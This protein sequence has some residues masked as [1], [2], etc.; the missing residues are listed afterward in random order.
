MTPLDRARR[1]GRATLRPLARALIRRR[2]AGRL[3][4]FVAAH[5]DGAGLPVFVVVVP[6]TLGW[7]E[8]CLRL[9]P[10]DVPLFLVGNGLRRR[11]RRRLARRFP[12]RPFFALSVPPGTYVRHGTVLDLLVAACPAD[13]AILDHDCYVFDRTLL[14]PVAWE[15][16]EFLAAVDAPGF[17][18]INPATGL[19]FPRTHF[20]VLR[21]E[22]FRDLRRRHGVGCEKATRTPARVAALLA[23]IGLGDHNFPPARMPFYDTL[24]L[25]MAVAFAEGARVRRLAAGEESITHIGGTARALNDPPGAAPPTAREP[26]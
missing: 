22:W 8:P 19:R 24:Q 1:I 11:E 6:R 14:E 26:V 12:E 21:R 16:E 7:L 23:G 18:S 20:L 5:W 2:D 9:I 25:A 17:H 3:R 10:P 4:V 13:F 15:A